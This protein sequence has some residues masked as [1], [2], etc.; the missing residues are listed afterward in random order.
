MN[1]EWVY[2]WALALLVLVPL[3]LIDEVRRRGGAFLFPRASSLEAAGRRG[4][5]WLLSH[6]PAILRALAFA[7]LVLAVARPR[8]A[9][10]VVEERAEGVPIM[11]AF[12]ISSSMLAEDFAPL[13]RLEVA[14]QTTRE[15]VAA[16]RH[17]PIGLVPFA[18]EAITQ[19]PLTTDDRVLFAALENLRIGLLEDGT[20]IGT[21][22][23]VAAARLQH[24]EG[25]EKVIILMS[26][27]ENNRGEIEPLEAARAAAQRGIRVYTVGVGTDEAAPVPLRRAPDGTVLQYAELPVGLDEPLMR[28]IA[29]LTGGT[30]FRADS[31]DAL[32]RVYRELDQM[33]GTPVRIRRYTEYSEW[34]LPLILLGTAL[35]LLEWFLR[36]SRWGKLPG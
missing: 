17:D 9:D 10:A 23:A 21:G 3:F 29:A 19:V 27:G 32:R 20:A 26:D 16:R 6:A 36:G 24:I 1:V 11:I 7:V 2:P 30:Y 18:G 35:L 8:T 31:P 33:V 12:D 4:G 14:R 5:H 34:Y 13:N 25:E 28:E 15:F 22:L